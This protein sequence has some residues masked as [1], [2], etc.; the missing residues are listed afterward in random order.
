MLRKGKY[1]FML[2]PKNNWANQ[3]S[4]TIMI[5]FVLFSQASQ[6]NICI[7]LSGNNNHGRLMG[8]RCETA[9]IKVST[10]DDALLTHCGLVT[11]L[12]D[13]DIGQHWLR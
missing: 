6:G 1:L 3:G 4:V 11:P 13:I 7:D 12:G 8:I 9:D 2:F 5:L 10:I